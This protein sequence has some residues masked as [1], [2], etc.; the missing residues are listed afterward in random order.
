[1]CNYRLDWQEVAGKLA[2]TADEVKQA[3]AFDEQKLAGFVADGL[4]T[5]DDNHIEMTPEGAL[6]VRNV[7]ASLDKLMLRTTR[8]FSKPV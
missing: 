7:A 3:T 5:A 1:M 6:F 8:T 2:L 4:I